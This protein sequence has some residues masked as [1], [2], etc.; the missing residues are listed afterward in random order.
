MKRL[1]TVILLLLFNATTLLSQVNHFN[2]DAHHKVSGTVH[3][4]DVITFAN[5]SKGVVFY[6][7][8]DRSGG[9]VVKSTDNLTSTPWANN[10]TQDI[11]GL[12]NNGNY[13]TLMSDIDGYANTAA[14]RAA[15]NTGSSCASGCVDFD[16]GWYVPAIGQLKKLFGVLPLLEGMGIPG[17]DFT[18]LV[19]NNQ[20]GYWSS[21]ART[22][23][24]AWTVNGYLSTTQGV[25]D[26][27]SGGHI[28]SQPKNTSCAVRAVHDF[29]FDEG[30][31]SYLWTPTNETT[32]EIVVSPSSTTQYCV[33]VTYGGQCPAQACQTITVLPDT[34]QT[35]HVTACDSYTW[36]NGNGQTYTSSGTYWYLPPNAGPCQG[37]DSLY[38]TINSS[39]TGIDT[40]VACESYT[41]INGVTYT[42]STNTPTY[43]LTNAAGCDSIVT[44]HLTINHD[45]YGTYN[46]TI[47]DYQLPY[48]WHGVTFTQ[49]GDQTITIP[50]ATADGC[51]SIVTL[52][53]TVNYA[54]HRRHAL[55][56]HGMARR[57][58]PRVTTPIYTPTKMAVRAPTRCT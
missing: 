50:N 48:T 35:Y 24:A 11:S 15:G 30:S 38:L 10:T 46:R 27:E 22:S 54:T 12:A 14:M 53:L 34:H 18:T 5:N 1:L 9:W 52:H 57:T 13:P 4:G 6:I 55:A 25:F 49:A 2:A 20:Y 51:D 42:Q 44:L 17:S 45:L 3:V 28:A 40:Q 21:T 58:R 29:Y 39:T 33:T 47:C 31:F 32:E 36:T 16:N 23:S 8:P 56:I 26:S 7:K 41:W 37:A 19:S 43:T